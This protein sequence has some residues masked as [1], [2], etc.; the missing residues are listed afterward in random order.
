MIC[1]CEMPVNEASSSAFSVFLAKN[2]EGKPSFVKGAK[3]FAG[4]FSL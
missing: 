3:T 1:R 4:N 2:V